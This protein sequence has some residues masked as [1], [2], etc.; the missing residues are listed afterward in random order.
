MI[1]KIILI[2]FIILLLIFVFMI[3]KNERV[4]QLR[5]KMIDI[6]YKASTLFIL[7]GYTMK[8]LVGIRALNKK[9]SYNNL[10]YSFTPLN[11]WSDLYAADLRKELIIIEK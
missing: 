2:M 9:Y 11:I 1:E 6:E 4:F 10:F 7:K 5:G 8:D 3:F